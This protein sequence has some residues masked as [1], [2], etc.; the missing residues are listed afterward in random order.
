MPIK[1]ARENNCYGKQLY[2]DFEIH[3]LSLCGHKC[4]FFHSPKKLEL[5]FISKKPIG[6]KKHRTR[7]SEAHSEMTERR[8][9]ESSGLTHI[10]SQTKEDTFSKNKNH[11][12][13]QRRKCD[14]ASFS[15]SSS[16][17]YL[18]LFLAYDENAWISRS[19]LPK[20]S[21][22]LKRL[23]LGRWCPKMCPKFVQLF[24]H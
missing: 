4:S 10:W 1:I 16:L 24:T 8:K 22:P 9:I 23:L 15:G 14:L 17:E 5:I 20:M 18:S 19:D 6:K 11:E 21:T 2:F 3:F 13:F 7:Q 12:T